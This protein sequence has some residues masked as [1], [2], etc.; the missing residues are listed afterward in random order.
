MYFVFFFRNVIEHFYIKFNKSPVIFKRDFNDLSY[1]EKVFLAFFHRNNLFNDT[2]ANIYDD[3]SLMNFRK[4]NFP[5]V[6]FFHLYFDKSDYTFSNL[7]YLRKYFIFFRNSKVFSKTFRRF[8]RLFFFKKYYINIFIMYLIIQK[9]LYKR[10]YNLCSSVYFETFNEN[11]LV[12]LNWLFFVLLTNSKGLLRTFDLSKYDD[13]YTYNFSTQITNKNIFKI[14]DTVKP[15]KSKIYIQY[16]IDR[17]KY[18]AKIYKKYNNFLKIFIKNYKSLYTFTYKNNVLS[19]IKVKLNINWSRSL[20]NYYPIRFSETSLSKHI[21]LNNINMYTFFFIRKNRIF[22]KGRYSRNRQLYRTG[23]YWCL[24]LNIMLVYGLYF[25]FYRFTFNF[26][27]F[28][29]GY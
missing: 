13:W 26:G 17:K 7:K 5:L 24:W 12:K 25:M 19:F 8:K 4:N 9:T 3:D 10:Y 16:N 18:I 22:N 21:N 20:K 27:Y 23:V 29:W 28:W 2:I 1:F 6:F 11:N 15:V 14:K